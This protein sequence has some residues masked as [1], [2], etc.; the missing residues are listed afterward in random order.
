VEDQNSDHCK[1]LLF[2]YLFRAIYN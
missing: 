2:T 1:H